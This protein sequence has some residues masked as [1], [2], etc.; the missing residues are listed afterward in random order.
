MRLFAYAYLINPTKFE[1]RGC[2]VNCVKV[3]KLPTLIQYE[4][5]RRGIEC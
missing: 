1:A 3:E 4:K 2:K 5:E